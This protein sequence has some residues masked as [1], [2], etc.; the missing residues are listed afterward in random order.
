MSWCVSQESNHSCTFPTSTAA[1]RNGQFLIDVRICA[2]VAKIVELIDDGNRWWLC[3]CCNFRNRRN[4]VDVFLY[5]G[6]AETFTKWQRETCHYYAVC[7]V[8][9][10]FK[11]WYL[12]RVQQH[13]ILR[14]MFYVRMFICSYEFMRKLC[15]CVKCIFMIRHRDFVHIWYT[16]RYRCTRI[17][18]T[19]LRVHGK[20]IYYSDHNRIVGMFLKLTHSWF[21]TFAQA[22]TCTTR[23]SSICVQSTMHKRIIRDHWMTTHLQKL[24][25]YRGVW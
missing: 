9:W 16:Q 14:P 1:I 22:S 4:A 6:I 11:R 13:A 12:K 7:R 3:L 25:S 5:A 23:I 19:R 24:K 15:M 17:L 10:T 2:I 21:Q 20:H 18:V 8:I